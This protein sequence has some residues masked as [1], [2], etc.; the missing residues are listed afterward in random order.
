MKKI[1]LITACVAAISGLTALAASA[2]TTGPQAQTIRT[3]DPMNANASMHRH[4]H[5][6]HMMHGG[7]M[8]GDMKKEGMSHGT[9]KEGGM[10]E[11]M[12]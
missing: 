11:G 1:I 5:H 2:Q 7:M 6:H 8:K 9:M 4:H 12:K 10:K 3:G